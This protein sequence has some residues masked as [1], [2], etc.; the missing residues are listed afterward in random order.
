MVAIIGAFMVGYVLA[1]GF[2]VLCGAL[3]EKATSNEE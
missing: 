2:S 1:G 3:I